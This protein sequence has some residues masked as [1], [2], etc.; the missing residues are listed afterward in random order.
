VLVVEHGGSSRSAAD[1]LEDFIQGK[2]EKHA[3]DGD[4]IEGTLEAHSEDRSIQHSSLEGIH[5]AK[6]WDLFLFVQLGCF[7]SK[8]VIALNHLSLDGL[9]SSIPDWHTGFQLPHRCGLLDQAEAVPAHGHFAEDSHT[10]T[11]IFMI[12]DS[13]TANLYLLRSILPK[14]L[15]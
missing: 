3:T 2:P 8:I 14:V 9:D 11:N 15:G 4:A 10:S 6:E 5:R 13:Q 12:A 1:E 7:V